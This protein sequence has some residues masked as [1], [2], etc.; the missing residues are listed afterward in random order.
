MRIN[1][2][3]AAEVAIIRY[4]DFLKALDETVNRCYMV[5]KMEIH[6]RCFAF[7]LKK[8][9]ETKIYQ[10]N[11]LKEIST[12]NF[13]QFFRDIFTFYETI[14]QS[15]IEQKVSDSFKFLI[16]YLIHLRFNYF[17]MTF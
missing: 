3:E 8:P 4:L 17:L 6:M 9:K 12:T 13:P 10:E 2:T 14:K 1:F 16:E 11:A 5:I 7:L 15:L